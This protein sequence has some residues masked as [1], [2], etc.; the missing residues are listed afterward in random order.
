[1]GRVLFKSGIFK[2]HLIH[3]STEKDSGVRI[4][5]NQTESYYSITKW[6]KLDYGSNSVFFFNFIFYDPRE[7]TFYRYYKH[8]RSK[9]K[10]ALKKS[11]IRDSI[12]NRG[13][14][15][16]RI[17]KSS[18]QMKVKNKEVHDNK[19]AWR[20]FLEQNVKKRHV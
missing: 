15:V 6:G 10:H 18:Q 17:T 8:I 14:K 9:T 12:L 7:I 5:V 20:G 3:V 16:Y 4:S 19:G 13:S 11:I 1:V 2:N